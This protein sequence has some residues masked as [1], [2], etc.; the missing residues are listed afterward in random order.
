MGKDVVDQ[1]TRRMGSELYS[2][3]RKQFDAPAIAMAE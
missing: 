3:E 1:T 2:K